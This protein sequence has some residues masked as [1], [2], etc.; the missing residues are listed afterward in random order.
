[1]YKAMFNQ[2]KETIYE[3]M[4]APPGMLSGTGRHAVFTAAEASF[5]RCPVTMLGEGE[6][7]RGLRP[8]QDDLDSDDSS[9]LMPILLV[10][11]EG[12]W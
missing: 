6:K 12:A 10:L 5:R 2:C 11:E 3:P 7:P 1:M 4:V 9:A 8:R